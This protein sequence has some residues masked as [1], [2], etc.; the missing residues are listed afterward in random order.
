MDSC[1][2]CKEPIGTEPA[3]ET[4]FG[5]MLHE[6]CRKSHE[7]NENERAYESWLESYYDGD[8]PWMQQEHYEAAAKERR[9]HDRG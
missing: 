8:G 3:I 5:D 4:D 2:H 9:E 1:I 7:E 6:R